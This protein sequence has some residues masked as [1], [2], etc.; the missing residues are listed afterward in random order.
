MN[1]LASNFKKLNKNKL[2]HYLLEEEAIMNWS[3]LKSAF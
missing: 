3:T 2:S 1:S